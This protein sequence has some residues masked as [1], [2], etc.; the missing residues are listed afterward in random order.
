MYIEQLI[1]KNNA[2]IIRDIPLKK[3]VNLITTLLIM[4]QSKTV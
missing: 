3:G 1:I 4:K 2:G